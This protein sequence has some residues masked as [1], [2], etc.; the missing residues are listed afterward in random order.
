MK[1]TIKSGLI[2]LFCCIMHLPASAGDFDGTKE[3]MCACIRVIECAPDGSCTEVSAEQ[4]GIPQFL[5][6]N[7]EEKTI[8]APQ[9]GENQTPSPIENLERIDGKLILQ[10]AE[11]GYREIR[12]GVGWSMAISEETGKMVL[13]ESGDQAAF[14]IFGACIAK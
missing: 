8:S 10:G 6:I 1:R 13:T 12:D 5:K 7:F 9:W 14:V 11:D 2:L 3:L 4:I